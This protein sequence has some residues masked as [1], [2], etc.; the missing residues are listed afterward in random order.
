M[1]DSSRNLENWSVLH[2]LQT[3]QKNIV[4]MQSVPL[5]PISSRHFWAW[6]VG[7]WKDGDGGNG[8]VAAVLKKLRSP[9]NDSQQSL[10][11]MQS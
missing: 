9:E 7:V 6:R 8:D 4:S 3:T 11:L 1:G 5:D 10:V 2:R